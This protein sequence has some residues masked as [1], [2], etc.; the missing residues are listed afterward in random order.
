LKEAIIHKDG[1]IISR[2][3]GQNSLIAIRSEKDSPQVV[4]G[5]AENV[6]HVVTFQ[7]RD[8]KLEPQSAVRLLV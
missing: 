1:K 4:N 7:I 2:Y 3:A 8:N 6:F 5:I